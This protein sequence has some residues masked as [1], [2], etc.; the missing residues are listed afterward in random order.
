MNAQAKYEFW[1]AINDIKSLEACYTKANEHLTDPS[2]TPEHIRDQFDDGGA[3][4]SCL[5]AV[6]E[7]WD[8]EAQK[9]QAK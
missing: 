2:L 3:T 5:M 4:G 1:E 6:L 9:E 7:H 8:D